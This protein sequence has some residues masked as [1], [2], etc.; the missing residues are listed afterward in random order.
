MAVCFG[1]TFG[2]MYL[3]PA[4]HLDLLG[5][6][7]PKRE[8]GREDSVQDPSL[9]CGPSQVVGHISLLL[10]SN[11][12][13]SGVRMGQDPKVI[14]D[15]NLG[16]WFRNRSKV[17]LKIW[18]KEVVLYI[19]YVLGLQKVDRWTG[20]IDEWMDR[21]IDGRKEGRIGSY[22]RCYNVKGYWVPMVK[23]LSKFMICQGHDT[24]AKG[25]DQK[26]SWKVIQWGRLKENKI[27]K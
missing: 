16:D 12:G 23:N 3:S 13:K 15:W 2:K 27:D 21:L 26:C 20:W 14:Q 8:W 22:V 19:Y 25:A 6:L 1:D 7:A 18:F 24:R 5:A 10:L 11:S 9:Y 4:L 17:I